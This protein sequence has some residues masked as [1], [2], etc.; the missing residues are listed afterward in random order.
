[1]ETETETVI[2][3]GKA[4]KFRASYLGGLKIPNILLPTFGINRANNYGGGG[5]GAVSKQ[6]GIQGAHELQSTFST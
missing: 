2:I 6:G 5:G 4:D 1:M 3:K